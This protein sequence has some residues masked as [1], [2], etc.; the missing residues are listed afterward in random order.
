VTTSPT[1]YF[2]GKKVSSDWYVV[3]TAARRAG[4]AFVVNQG[5][6]TLAE[7]QAFYDHF[8]KYGYPRAAY[9]SQSAPH[10]KYGQPDHAL[11]IPAPQVYAFAAWLRRQGANPRWTVSGEPWHIEITLVELQVLSRKFSASTANAFP[12]LRIGAKGTSVTRLQRLLQD[13][14]VKDAPKVDGVFGPDTL[15][16]VRRFQ[17]SV[18]LK[19]DGVVGSGTWKALRS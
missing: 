15:S 8:M 13:K 18:N 17:R 5:R 6:R 19:P 14:R 2:D 7:Q 4:V 10:I 11:D 12:T 3:L 1:M 9:P 16:A